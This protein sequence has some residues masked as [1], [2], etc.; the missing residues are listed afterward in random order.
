MTST[1]G[2]CYLSGVRFDPD[3]DEPPCTVARPGDGT[4]GGKMST[5]R[6]EFACHLDDQEE[7]AAKVIYSSE[8]SFGLVFNDEICSG[9]IYD[10]TNETEKVTINLLGLTEFFDLKS[11]IIT[12][13]NVIA[14][15]KRFTQRRQTLRKLTINPKDFYAKEKLRSNNEVVFESFARQ[16][17]AF[18]YF[19]EKLL[20]QAP[21]HI[22]NPLKLFAFESLVTGKRQF[23]VA[24][25]STF[26]T[27]YL[28]LEGPKRHVYEL[29][30]QDFPCRL[31]F[32]LEFSIPANPDVV[33]IILSFFTSCNSYI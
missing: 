17:L 4:R 24:D 23:L 11:I 22:Q 8:Y 2:T 15:L 13:K 1:V 20:G 3:E 19:D 21:S 25:I 28:S 29:I 5:A 31:Y 12:D 27:R 14:I 16:E 9:M 7:L 30:R 18:R 33:G 32:D 6:I 26:M 10:T